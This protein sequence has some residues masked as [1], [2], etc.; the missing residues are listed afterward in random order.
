MTLSEEIVG[1]AH[2]DASQIGSC[3]CM[4]DDYEVD[5]QDFKDESGLET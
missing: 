1:Q 4:D 5:F 3:Q 2:E